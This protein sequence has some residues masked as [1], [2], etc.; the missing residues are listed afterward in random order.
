MVTIENVEYLVVGKR[1][2]ED[3]CEVNFSS[4]SN[5]KNISEVT[6]ILK[7]PPTTAKKNSLYTELSGLFPDAQITVPE[8]TDVFSDY[9][10][11]SSIYITIALV[12]MSLINISYLY[13]YLLRRRK[14]TYAIYQICGC[15]KLKGA[16]IFLFELLILTIAPF[17][18]ALLI[19]RLFLEKYII[20]DYTYVYRLTNIGMLAISLVFFLILLAAF[21]PTIISYCSQTPKQLQANKG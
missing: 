15:T 4:L 12:A 14:N 18:A 13:S 19:Y 1:N 2:Y 20:N 11:N 5:L 9:A 6:V 10:S 8:G 7:H 21:I 16:C 17:I 3:F